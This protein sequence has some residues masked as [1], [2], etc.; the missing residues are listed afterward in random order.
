MFCRVIRSSPAHRAGRLLVLYVAP[1]LTLAGCT[2]LGPEYQEPKLS[3]ADVPTQWTSPAETSADTE[4]PRSGPTR[5]PPWWMEFSDS[6]L[7]RLVKEAFDS[8]PTLEAAVAK[9]RQSQ[10][11]VA[12]ARANASP[13]VDAGANSERSASDSTGNASTESGLSVNS[14]WEI[15]LFGAVRRGQEAAQAREDAQ[16]AT[17]ADA[18]IS[19]SADVTDAYLSHR[20]CQSQVALSEQ[21]LASRI[22][23]EKLTA[24]SVEVGFTAPYEGIRST[25]SAAWLAV[26]N[27]GIVKSF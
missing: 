20:A 16:R 14:S 18:R 23:T 1:F 15:D 17:L 24:N 4:L 8:S 12:Q 27:A 25:A 5:T 9:L 26:S 22:A 2:V 21:D 3:E 11:Y 13:S 7:N 10:T 19:L 6:A